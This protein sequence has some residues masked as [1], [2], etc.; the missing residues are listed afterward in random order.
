[1]KPLIS[2]ALADVSIRVEN[3]RILYSW[4][5]S[6]IKSEKKKASELSIVL[7]S[8]DYLLDINKRFLNHNY[9]TDIIT[10]DYTSEDKV[11]GELYISTDRVRDNAKKFKVSFEQELHR[12][13]I[14]GVLHLCGYG[15]KNEAQQKVMRG[16][17][18]EKLKLLKI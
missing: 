13:M 6:V 5:G 15:D 14:H 3:K 17:E 8:D 2:I 11:S 12:V 1:M 16:K 4:I 18:N 7:C 10:F 9:Y